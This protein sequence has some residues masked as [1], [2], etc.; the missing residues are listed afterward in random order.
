MT[1]RIAILLAALATPARASPGIEHWAATSTTAIGITGDIT[2]SPDRLAMAGRS[3]P[4]ARAADRPAFR[5]DSG[6]SPARILRV[7]RPADPVLLHGNRM[8]GGL[9]G[10][11]APVRWIA[12]WRETMFSQTGLEMAVFSSIEQPT[13]EG[14]PGLCGTFLYTRP[15]LHGHETSS[16]GLTRNRSDSVV[17]IE[18]TGSQSGRPV[19]EVSDLAACSANVRRC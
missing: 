10:K 12:V 15:S 5:H 14:S 11:S 3:L 1:A 6:T 13:G 7:T 18:R 2:L 17:R 19:P 9:A 4:L 8:C 16:D